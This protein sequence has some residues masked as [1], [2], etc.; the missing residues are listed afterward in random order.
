[1]AGCELTMQQTWSKEVR[2]G[3]EARYME[4]FAKQTA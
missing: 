1:M 4:D 2:V 3:Q